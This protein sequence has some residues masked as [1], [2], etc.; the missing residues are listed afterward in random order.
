[1]NLTI[2][3]DGSKWCLYDDEGNKLG[4]YESKSEAVM[5]KRK[6]EDDE[7]ASEKKAEKETY[8]LIAAFNALDP[9]AASGIWNKVKDSPHPHAACVEMMK[10]KGMED[11]HAFC[12]AVEKEAAGTTPAERT[13]KKHSYANRIDGVEIFAPGTHNGDKYAEQDVDELIASF[14]KLDYRPALKQ[15]H[16]KD[17][18]GLTALGWVENLRKQG[19]KLIA[20]FVDI[21]DAVY[22]AIKDRRLDR[23][24]AEIFWNFK[25]GGETYRR[26]LKAVALL[27]AEI[28]AVAGLRPLHEHFSDASADALKYADETP[29]RPDPDAIKSNAKEVEMTPDELKQLQDDL[30]AAQDAVAAEKTA[31][32]AADIKVAALT[33]QI[34]VG[35]G[36]LTDAARAIELAAQTTD[37][38]RL[39]ADL[40][41]AKAAAEDERGKRLAAEA[42]LE[43]NAS[44]V[45]R[46]AQ[47]NRDNEIERVVNTCRIPAFRPFVRQF[48]QISADV[49]GE[50]RVYAQDG[51]FITPTEAVQAMVTWVND[52]ASK[53]FTVYSR[54]NDAPLAHDDPGKEVHERVVRYR[55]EHKE[56]S[57]EAAML[58]V[59]S[60]DPALKVKY[61][62]ASVNAA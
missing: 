61:T 52:N 7:A 5:A 39:T 21:P 57:Y 18:T 15:G 48:L 49:P 17:E 1:V 29:L 40:N 46:L 45:K 4:E 60:A 20:D 54:G 24:S 51:K 43:A 42:T 28:P 36:T 16:V 62:Q 3:R 59:F 53:L 30:K 22:A 8:A 38:S 31:R 12:A 14:G 33:A 2:K 55:A 26:A 6:H 56:S 35:K 25:R 27:G 23:V 13:A 47:A 9:K 11:P 44:E 10:G 41:V 58:A 19:G 37:V 34:P 50:M 32:E